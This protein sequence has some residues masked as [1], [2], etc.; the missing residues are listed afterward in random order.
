[1]ESYFTLDG[2]VAVASPLGAGPWDPTMLHG[3][4]PTG[5]ITWIAE[6]LPS[7]GPMRIVRLTIDL[8]RPVPIG[9]L[10]ITTELTRAGREIQ[11]W[12][13][14]L[15]A[16]EKEVVHATVLKIREA[17]DPLPD[18]VA[19]PGLTYAL[20]EDCPEEGRFL[21]EEGYN[22]GIEFRRAQPLTDAE[23]REAVWFRIAR[24]FLPGVDTPALVRAAATG[25]YC[26]ALGAPLDFRRWTYINADLSVH[27][28]RAPVG[29]WMLL[30]AE[31]WIGPEGRGIAFGALADRQGFVGRA[32]QCLVVAPRP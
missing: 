22:S 27:M 29:E 15:S 32:I 8:K 28:V 4:A 9:P 7:D 17:H 30:A 31:G 5:L 2:D 1:M 16:G 12:D 6:G 3:G 25:D 10:T 19:L 13:I 14:R 11:T 21:A 20:P 24:P 23:T 26:N 18:G